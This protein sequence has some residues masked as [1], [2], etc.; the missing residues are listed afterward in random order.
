MSYN[1]YTNYETWCVSL[2]LDNDEPNHLWLRNLVASAASSYDK[3]QRLKEYVSYDHNPLIDT[4]T[5][6]TDLLGG[7]LSAVNWHEIIENA[8]EG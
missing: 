8:M 3:A 7:A 4:A 5:M 6:Y 2:W 1:G